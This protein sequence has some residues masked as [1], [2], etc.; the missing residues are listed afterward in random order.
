MSGINV[1]FNLSVSRLQK[2]LAELDEMSWTKILNDEDL[3]EYLFI[4]N[5]W[6]QL[7][8][9]LLP[10]REEETIDLLVEDGYHGWG[11]LYHSLAV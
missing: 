6:R 1:Q 2:G 10:T 11:E 7:A 3:T 8:R 9:L 5:E 4:L